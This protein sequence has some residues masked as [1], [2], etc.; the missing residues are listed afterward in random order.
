LAPLSEEEDEDDIFVTITVSPSSFQDMLCLLRDFDE[1]LLLLL[2]F[3]FLF[4]L[5]PVLN[6]RGK[7]KLRYAI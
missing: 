1:L 4:F 3:Y 7:K 6:S 2:L 5:T